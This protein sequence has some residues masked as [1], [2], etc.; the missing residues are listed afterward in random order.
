MKKTYVT[1]LTAVLV[2]LSSYGT[3]IAIAQPNQRQGTTVLAKSSWSR[4]R[5]GLLSARFP[6]PPKF[7]E[8]GLELDLGENLLLLNQVSG[9]CNII[10]C[11]TLASMILDQLV[12]SQDGLVLDYKK[13]AI[14]FNQYSTLQFRVSHLYNSGAFIEGEILVVNND[15]YFV[16]GS[17]TAT[18]NPS[19]VRYFLDS[20][21]I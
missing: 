18:G 12:H 11:K 19:I 8:D 4:R 17:S 9:E 13:Q 1:L 2:V 15:L 3:S 14:K 10:N 6:S 16:L 21:R 5:V 20:L 7:T